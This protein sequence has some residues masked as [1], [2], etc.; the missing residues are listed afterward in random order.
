MILARMVFAEKLIPQEIFPA[1]IGF[2]PGG[3]P[4]EF[5]VDCKTFRGKGSGRIDLG[6]HFGPEKKY[7]APPPKFSA[8]SLPPPLPHPPVLGNPASWDFQ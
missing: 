1:C 6:G 4:E 7:L 2:A 3:I 8:D 5:T